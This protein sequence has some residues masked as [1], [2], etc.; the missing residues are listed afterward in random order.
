MT[1]AEESLNRLPFVRWDRFIVDGADL[2]CYG[3]IDRP[4]AGCQASYVSR[5]GEFKCPICPRPTDRRADFVVLRLGPA[6]EPLWFTTSSAERSEEIAAFV[7]GVDAIAVG[8]A[9]HLECQR[10]EDEMPGVRNAV[11]L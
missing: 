1:P 7:A 6:G 8:V 9:E 5:G 10:I 11:R 3:W 2:Y 4:C